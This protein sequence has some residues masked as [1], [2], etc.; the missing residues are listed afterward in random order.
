LK[1][2]SYTGCIVRFLS[3][4]VLL[5]AATA[6]AAPPVPKLEG[7]VNDYAHVLSPAQQ[8][9]LTDFLLN[10]EQQ[11]GNQIV[12]LTVPSLD[13]D[14]IDDFS[15]KVARAWNLGQK[16]KKN[17]VLVT[18]AINDHKIRIEVT[19]GLQSVLTDALSSQIIRNEM[20]PNFKAG[21]YFGGLWAGVN[22]ID[23][24]IHGQYKATGTP[25]HVQ[26]KPTVD[27]GTLLFWMI[28][29]IVILASHLRFRRYR[30]H[31]LGPVWIP[32]NSG[33]FSSGGFFGGGGGGG[34]GYSGGGGGGGFD[35]G[36]ASGGW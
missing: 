26:Q 10:Q 35:G 23:K 32:G 16:D 11:T 4:G 3:I 13:G 6:H 31:W 5:S 15:L 21:D 18:V 30:N 12:I 34:G 7:P 9:Q 27:V 19:G 33:G 29:L 17:G 25:R 2:K 20:T 1:P 28:V 8:T 36:G 24:A 22:A 14:A